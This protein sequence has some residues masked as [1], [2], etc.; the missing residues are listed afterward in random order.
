M[1]TE[2]DQ[3]GSDPERKINL[4]MVKKE[5]SFADT[6][7]FKVPQ[8]VLYHYDVHTSTWVSR[9]QRPSPAPLDPAPLSLQERGSVEGA[10]FL[11]SR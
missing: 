2:V 10:F 9:C 1:V 4:G 8:V 5:D 6:I 7:L 3:K 11:Y